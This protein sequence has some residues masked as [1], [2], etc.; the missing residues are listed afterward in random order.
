M[1]EKKK[2]FTVVERQQTDVQGMVE[3]EKSPVDKLHSNDWFRQESV[4]GAKNY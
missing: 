1:N 3:W 4:M 2:L